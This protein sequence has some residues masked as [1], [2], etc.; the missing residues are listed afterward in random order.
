[1]ICLNSVC[2]DIYVLIIW[3]CVGH[4]ASFSFHTYLVSVKTLL[5]IFNFSYS[6]FFN[7][8]MN[9][10][11][12]FIPQLLFLFCLF[13]YLVLLVFHKWV[14]YGAG[15][16]PASSPSCAPSILITFINMVSVS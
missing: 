1:M 6:R 11:C 15:G 10:Y 7:R 2:A 14:W 13:V 8:P 9:I 4:L 16:D 5:F 12:E 3:S